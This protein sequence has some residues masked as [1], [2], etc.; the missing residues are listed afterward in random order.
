MYCLEEIIREIFG[1]CGE[2]MNVRLSNK[3]FCHIRFSEE[4]AVDQALTLSG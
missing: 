4:N 3:K 1:F 2:I